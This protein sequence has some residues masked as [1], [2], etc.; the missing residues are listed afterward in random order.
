MNK[1]YR[2][3][4]IAVGIA[5]IVVAVRTCQSSRD[6]LESIQNQ[7][8]AGQSNPE[9]T[10]KDVTLE[11]PDDNGGLLWRV[12]AEEATYSPDRRLASL[13]SPEGEL[14]QDGKLLYEVK[15]DQG[16]IRE[17]GESIFLQ[18]N[19]VAVSPDNQVTLRGNSLEWT[20]EEDL[21]LVRDNISGDHPQLKAAAQEARLFNRTQR[22]ELLRGVMATTQQEPWI[23][24]ESETLIWLLDEEKLETDMPLQV[25]Q[26]VAKDDSTVTDRLI[27]RQGEF[28]LIEQRATLRQQVQLNALEIP[29]QTN[30]DI[31]VWDTVDST[32][33]IDTPVQIQYPRRKITANANQAR[34]NLNTE[35]LVLNGSVRSVDQERQSLL[36][37]DQ[38]TW[39]IET[40]DVEGQGNVS[41][42]QQ[43]PAATVNGDRAVGN[44]D[45]Q[46]VLVTGRNVVTEIVPSELQ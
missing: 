34:L 26:Y 9:L 23:G 41:Y 5:V 44:L 21:L 7:E 37:A 25:E 30:S 36:I 4:M 12:K 2:F 35:I 19:I 22:L 15:A 29:L 27:G 8:N 31:A 38:L 33:V 40:Q 16:E 6:T 45:E 43:D 20:P 28:D 46:T 1:W 11:Q 17:N 39:N 14:F 32:V 10:L 42:R 13:K 18:G 3:T 24:F